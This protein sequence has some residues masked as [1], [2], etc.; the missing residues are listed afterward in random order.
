MCGT[1]AVGGSGR[2]TTTELRHPGREETSHA[3][4]SSQFVRSHRL[5]VKTSDGRQPKN[6]PKIRLATLIAV[7]ILAPAAHAEPTPHN[8]G[9][10]PVV[11]TVFNQPSNIPGKSVEAVAVSYPPGGKSGAHHHAK[12]A[13]IM[14]YVISDAVR[15]QVEGDINN[16][17]TS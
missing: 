8:S 14:A 10:N 15:S 4:G 13:F 2:L 17:K 5:V 1:G 12:W 11:R 6:G 9:Q 7:A 16:L 3:R